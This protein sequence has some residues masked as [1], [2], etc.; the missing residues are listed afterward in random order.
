M[1][2][3]RD[4]G[5]ILQA[6]IRLGRVAGVPVG[7]HFSWFII[8]A[9]ITF[10]LAAHFSVTNPD[11]AVPLVWSTAAFTAV[12]FFVTL[13]AH[14]LSH[15]IV[16]R[17]RGL[18]VRSITLFALGGIA[19]IDKEANTARTEFYIAIVGPITSATIGI[20]C[21]LAA[22]AMGWTVE[23]GAGVAPA[24]LG[25]LGSI[26]ILLAAFNLLP[27]FPLDGGRVLRAVLWAIYKNADRAT[28]VAARTGQ[29]VAGLF[30]LFGLFAFFT[31]AGLGGLWLA[32]IGWFLLSAAQATYAQATI[33]EALRDI[34][35]AEVMTN[36]CVM[37]DER[38]D[39]QSLVDDLI[40]RRG[41]RCIMVARNGQILGLVTPN[42]V[43]RVDR[44]RWP[45]TTARDV[46][47]PLETLKTVSPDTPVAEAFAT[48]AREDV[49]QLPV[50]SAGHLEGFVSRGQILRL[51]ESRAELRA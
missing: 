23:G 42:E 47:R 45:E 29:F 26:N 17:A 18:P 49:N 9:L 25:W 46:M 39:L 10:S 43:R 34:S 14:E 27:G 1:G 3:G 15:A 28:R 11:W 20:V 32:F 7:L 13:L 19:Q 4:R 2:N 5:A 33:T 50:V 24:V 35:V 12:L 40:L 8:A 38:T 22:Q 6:S 36:D 21:I 44:V 16:A 51:I 31:G 48:M 41:R 37:V 30:I